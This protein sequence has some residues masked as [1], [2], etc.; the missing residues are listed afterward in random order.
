M[1]ASLCLY[2][3]FQFWKLFSFQNSMFYQRT[4]FFFFKF[5]QW[6]L[7]WFINIG[8]F[9]LF[10]NNAEIS[11]TMSNIQYMFSRKGN[12]KCIK[13]I[14]TSYVKPKIISLPIQIVGDNRNVQ[15]IKIEKKNNSYQFWRENINKKYNNFHIS[16]FFLL[17]LN[18]KYYNFDATFTEMSLLFF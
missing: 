10:G 8:M 16:Y 7:V 14:Y 18:Q 17:F 1:Y 13:S 15:P 3:Q 12:K 5:G 2:H 6:Y 4:F 11:P 9:Q